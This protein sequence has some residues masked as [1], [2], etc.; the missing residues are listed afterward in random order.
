MRI[1]LG[2]GIAVC[3]LLIIN[4]TVMCI[5]Q[6]KIIYGIGYDTGTPEYEVALALQMQNSTSTEL[7]CAVE[8]DVIFGVM[9]EKNGTSRYVSLAKNS[10]GEYT[11]NIN[12][13]YV[14]GDSQKTLGFGEL[15]DAAVI[16]RTGDSYI[17]LVPVYGYNTNDN[18][19]MDID[20]VRVYDS[21][22]QNYS[23]LKGNNF[24]LFYDVSN[25][26]FQNDYKVFLEYDGKTYTVL[27][28]EDTRIYHKVY[29][30]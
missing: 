2:M 29:D 10:S 15:T 23:V 18:N 20:K 19:V 30:N 22:G 6:Q 28:M 13:L 21:D 3:V 8:D 26:L 11:S 9:N 4:G 14:L 12:E 27:D 17:S 7:E 25:Q 24:A 16:Y 5:G 1:A